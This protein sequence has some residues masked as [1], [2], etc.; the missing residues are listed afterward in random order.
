[1]KRLTQLDVKTGTLFIDKKG[2]GRF[3]SIT[4]SNEFYKIAKKLYDYEEYI[5]LESDNE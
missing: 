3:E 1:M 2:V 4:S 5:S